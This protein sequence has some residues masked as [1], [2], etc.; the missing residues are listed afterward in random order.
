MLQALTVTSTTAPS[1]L[2]GP[3]TGNYKLMISASA[4]VTIGPL[5]GVTYPIPATTPVT[6]EGTGSGETLMVAGAATV[7][8]LV[9]R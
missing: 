9:L 3:L 5:N 1:T 4:A 7:N 8:V 6:L 2:Y